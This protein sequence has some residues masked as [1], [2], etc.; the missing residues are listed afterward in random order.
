MLLYDEPQ[1]ES[2]WLPLSTPEEPQY[3]AQANIIPT[4]VTPAATHISREDIQVKPWLIP[5]FK[6]E[7]STEPIAEHTR[8]PLEPPMQ[9]RAEADSQGLPQKQHSSLMRLKKAENSSLSGSMSSFGSMASVYSEAGGKGDYDISGEV[10]V[11]VHYENGQL[12]IHVERARGLAA[13]NHNGYSNPYVKTYI[14]PDKAKHTKQKTSVKKKT[15]DPVYNE[16][17]TVRRV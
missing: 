10:L 5:V 6:E 2:E 3:P 11:G 15:L 13:A 12:H 7:S 16:T 1:L 8:E 4:G 14:L 17:L 9:P